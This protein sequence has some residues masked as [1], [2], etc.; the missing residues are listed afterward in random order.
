MTTI[1]IRNTDTSPRSVVVKVTGQPD[2]P[3]MPGIETSVHLQENDDVTIIAGDLVEREVSENAQ[4]G[5]TKIET[6]TQNEE[7]AN[8]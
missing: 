6:Q 3:L 1:V 2:T 4:E 7:K 8:G 5:E